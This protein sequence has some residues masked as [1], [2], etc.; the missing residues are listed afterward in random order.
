MPKRPRNGAV[1]SPA[2]VVAPTKVNFGR[3]SFIE[4]A[5][6]PCPIIMSNW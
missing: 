6:V 5:A 4:R 3:S 1:M 2:R